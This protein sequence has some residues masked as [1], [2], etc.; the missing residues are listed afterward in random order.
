MLV[1]DPQQFF[2]GAQRVLFVHAHPDD[3]SISTGGTIAALNASGAVAAVLTLTR[4]EQ[5]EAASVQFS[6]L[7]GTEAFAE[8]RITELSRALEALHVTQHAFLGSGL[9]RAASLPP[10]RY[11][12]SGMQWGANGLAEAASHVGAEALTSASIA[13]AL[14]DLLAY[15]DAIG[16]DA[17]VS[18]DQ[19]GGYGHPDHVLAHQLTRAAAVGLELPFWQIVPEQDELGDAAAAGEFDLSIHDV[20]N[21]LVAK[22]SALAAHASQLTLAKNTF[23]LSGGQAHQISA[24][25]MFMRVP[26]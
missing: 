10:R 7:E 16:A 2:D 1:S 13:E 9:A 20:Q 24:R 5:G 22:R 21:W 15:A 26:E 8:H 11:E 18:Y 14:A 12:D 25:E 4:G 6:H 17:L 23:V 19:D 3:E